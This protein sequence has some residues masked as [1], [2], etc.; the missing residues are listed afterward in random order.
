VQFKDVRDVSVA[1]VHARCL[2]SDIFVDRRV[3]LRW[4]VCLLLQWSAK[5]FA[6]AQLVEDRPEVPAMQN[7][8]E[9]VETSEHNIADDC[10]KIQGSFQQHYSHS[11]VRR[12]Q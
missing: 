1:G 9:H 6:S 7:E 8:H 2:S 4:L 12:F 5:A 11:E 3:R 10:Q